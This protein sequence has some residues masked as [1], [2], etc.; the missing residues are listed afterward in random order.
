MSKRQDES[1]HDDYSEPFTEL[2][3]RDVEK[4]PQVTTERVDLDSEVP[5]KSKR[6]K[7][8]KNDFKPR[9][10]IDISLFD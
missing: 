2:P 6:L 1:Y 10:H 7:T 4:R 8:A 9:D 3:M 5:T